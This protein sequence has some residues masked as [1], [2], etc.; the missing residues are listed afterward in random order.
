MSIIAVK[1]PDWLKLKAPSPIVLRKMKELLDDLS[2]HTVCEEAN[3]PNQGVCFANGTATFLIMGDT[4]TRN[5]TFCAI[6]KG[7]PSFLDRREPLN[8]AR[9]VA[10]L[11]LRHVVITSVTRDDLPDGGAEHFAETVK[12][13]RQHNPGVTIEVLIPDFQ[14]LPE[15]IKTIVDSRP[16]VINHNV[17]TVP[18]LYCK[19]RP[20][21]DYTRSLDL[22]ETAKL[23]DNK[24]VTKSG[25]MLGLG[26]NSQE[27]IATMRD[28]RNA[29]CDI[30]TIGQYLPPSKLHH[31]LVEYVTPSQ[32]QKYQSIGKEIGFGSVA[33]GPFVRS[34]FNAASLYATVIENRGKPIWR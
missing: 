18:S 6:K 17:E 25:I 21:A 29:Q 31:P 4:C 9:A 20:G 3:C 30:L 16:E 8:V 12:I 2:L 33:S 1:H 23:L 11:N 24:I 28:L 19:V 15:A 26:E 27:I 34:S 14:G 5:C 10:I 13:V 7:T 22:L 32:F